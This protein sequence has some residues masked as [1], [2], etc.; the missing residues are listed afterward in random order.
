MR[1]N[2]ANDNGL[3]YLLIGVGLGLLAGLLC[4]PKRGDETREE[5]RRRSG[6]GLDYLTEEAEKIRSEADRW[7]SNMKKRW[8]EFRKPAGDSGG[9][10]SGNA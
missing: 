4:A 7:L 6:E 3:R 1:A 9:F 5:L 8:S 2:H 10:D